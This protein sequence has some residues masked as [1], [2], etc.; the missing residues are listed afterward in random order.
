MIIYRAWYGNGYSFSRDENSYTNNH[1]Q[2]QRHE[3]FNL[4]EI[5][6]HQS[7]CFGECFIGSHNSTLS[8]ISFLSDSNLL[9]TLMNI[10]FI[11]SLITRRVCFELKMIQFNERFYL[12]L[13]VL[14]PSVTGHRKKWRYLL[15]RS[16][17][18][19]RRMSVLYRIRKNI[20]NATTD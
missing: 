10:A 19:L 14:P 1:F 18:T 9:N 4:D 3:V 8:I 5:N 2:H 20:R 15:R 7:Q 16:S 11:S 6:L 12:T 13:L 17:T